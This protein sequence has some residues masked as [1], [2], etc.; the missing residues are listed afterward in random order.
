[1]IAGDREKKPTRVLQ[2]TFQDRT[3]VCFFS[4]FELNFPTSILP[5]FPPSTFPAQN[6]SFFPSSSLLPF[7]RVR[8]GNLHFNSS[9]LPYFNSSILQFFPT[10]LLSTKDFSFFRVRTGNSPFNISRP[11]LFFL[12]LIFPASIFSSS[13]WK[14]TLQFFLTSI[15]QFF[16]TSILPYFLTSILQFFNSSLL[17]YSQQRTFH[18]SEFELEIRPST[19]PAQKLFQYWRDPVELEFE[20]NPDTLVGTSVSPVP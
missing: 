18:F 10:S 12:S 11:K 4:E 13:N 19:F 5:P 1:M 8:T 7:F 16:N 2:R 14:F 20:L 3:R 6:F 17:P 15:L 9:L